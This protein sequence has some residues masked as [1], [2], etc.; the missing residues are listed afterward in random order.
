MTF[1]KFKNYV[2]LKILNVVSKIEKFFFSILFRS[3]T[4]HY[5]YIKMKFY[6]PNA[7]CRY[8]AKTFA[9][10]EP[11]T[12]RWIESFE[13]GSTFWDIGANIGIYS[14]YAAKKRNCAVYAFE[15]SL[16]NLE[17]LARNIDINS[18][19]EKICI[20]PIALNDK[21]TIS[22]FQHS[23]LTWGGALS[24]FEHKINDSG[25]KFDN[26]KLEYRTLGLTIDFVAE[27]LK[28][29]VPD[30]LKIDVDG[31]EHLILKGGQKTMRKVKQIL[32]EINED[33][34]LQENECIFL[35]KKLGFSL[36]SKNNELSNSKRTANQIWHRNQK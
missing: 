27:T 21:V 13:D 31:I 19:N 20:L 35:L 28:L 10:K 4:I 30:Y 5:S 17:V 18:V 25:E 9:T 34:L 22:T 12:L 29:K 6:T 33:F 16:L 1:E 3:K 23:S 8:R 15:P 14:I 36:I 32:I 7:L 26:A 11:D 24:T 2:E